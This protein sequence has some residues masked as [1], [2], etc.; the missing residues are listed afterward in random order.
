[1][2]ADQAVFATTAFTMMIACI[3]LV[4][5]KQLIVIMESLLPKKSLERLRVIKIQFC[6]LFSIFCSVRNK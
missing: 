3:T 2:M 1:M 6:I 5:L 4:F